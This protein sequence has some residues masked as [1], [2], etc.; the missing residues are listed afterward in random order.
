MVHGAV[1]VL[2]ADARGEPVG[3]CDLEARDDGQGHANR[4][5]GDVLLGVVG[6][7]G[8]WDA[9]GGDGGGGVGGFGFVGGRGG[10]AGGWGGDV[11]YYLL[12]EGVV[13]IDQVEVGLEGGRRVW[14]CGCGEDA[15]GE[16]G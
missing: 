15:G 7:E 11:A 10:W 6:G 5:A 16:V 8:F 12:A 14:R 1:G 13:L 4:A 3:P 9:F 2:D